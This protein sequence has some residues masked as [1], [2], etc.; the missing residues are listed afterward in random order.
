MK[1]KKSGIVPQ[2][3]AINI[4][5]AGVVF[6]TGVFL[7]CFSQLL[8]SRDIFVVAGMSILVGAAKMFGYFSNDMY[9]LAFQFDFAT[10]LFMSAIG[11][12]V[13]VFPTSAAVFM[14]LLL[15]IYVMLDGM[16]KIQ[17]A[18]DAKKFGISKW[19]LILS[20]SIVLSLVGILAAVSVL[21]ELAEPHVLC[22]AA[23]LADGCE[24]IW[25]TAYTVRVRA[26]KKNLLDMLEEKEDDNE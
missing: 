23:L 12:L 3:K 9:R 21:K 6:V 4:A 14:P 25:I 10:G 1:R 5:V 2:A 24:N 11:V 26:T 22:G 19:P 20:T 16:Q 13:I 8:E 18:L 17:I 7:L 15:G